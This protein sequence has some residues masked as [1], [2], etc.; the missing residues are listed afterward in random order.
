MLVKLAGRSGVVSPEGHR[1]G[2]AIAIHQRTIVLAVGVAG[3][4]EAVTS[5]WGDRCRSELA[6][7]AGSN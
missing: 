4:S 1:Q 7:A 3:N 5:N 2:V 6:I